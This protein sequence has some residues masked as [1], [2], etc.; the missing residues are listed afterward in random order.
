M[1]EFFPAKSPFSIVIRP[2]VINHQ[3]TCGHA[4]FQDM[5]RIAEDILLILPKSKF[6]PGIIDR[7][8]EKFVTQP[9]IAERKMLLTGGKIRPF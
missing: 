7:V 3:H 6:Y 4:V 1:R 2:S 9:D 8:F 5:I